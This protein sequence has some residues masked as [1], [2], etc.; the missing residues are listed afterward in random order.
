MQYGNEEGKHDQ[1]LDRYGFKSYYVVWKHK[2][3]KN[4][5][6]QDEKFK[7]YYVVWKLDIGEKKYKYIDTFKSYYVVWKLLPHPHYAASRPSV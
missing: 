5:I 2:Y 7:S 4:K 6:K 3:N 1:I